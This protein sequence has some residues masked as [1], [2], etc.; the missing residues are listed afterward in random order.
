MLEGG[1]SRA[2]HLERR[3][4]VGRVDA[5][6]VFGIQAVE[7]VVRHELGRARIIDERIELPPLVQGGLHQPLAVRVLGDIG[8]HHDGFSASIGD[9]LGLLRALRVID[10]HAPATLGELNRRRGADAGRGTCDDCDF[11]RVHTVATGVAGE[12]T[13][14]GSLSGGA[15]SRKRLR[16]CSRNQCAS[17]L[18]YQISPR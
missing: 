16:L 15:V 18:R 17:S 10:H 4:H 7:L 5:L 12:P 14:P 11:F 1:R 3:N 13:A 6:E 8:L 2:A 9:L